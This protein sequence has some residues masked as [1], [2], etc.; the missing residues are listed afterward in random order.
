MEKLRLFPPLKQVLEFNSYESEVDVLFK[1]DRAINKGNMFGDS[2]EFYKQIGLQNGHN[3]IDISCNV[4]A[5]VLASHPGWIRESYMDSTGGLGVVIV[6]FD[7]YIWKDGSEAHAKT[8]YWHNSKNL[9]KVGNKVK[10]GQK[11]ALAG[12]TGFSTGPHLHHGGKQCDKNGNTLN[13]GNGH[14]GAVDIY[15]YYKFWDL[16]PILENLMLDTDEKIKLVYQ[17]VLKRDPDAEGAAFWKGKSVWDF[18]KAASSGSENTKLKMIWSW[19]K[20]FLGTF[21]K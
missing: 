5:E 1:F 20:Y 10:V 16:H 15:D 12:S 3:G 18:L 17:A 8:I 19:G 9:V 14:L 13:W 2:I 11:I 21:G 6:S 7:P 4:G